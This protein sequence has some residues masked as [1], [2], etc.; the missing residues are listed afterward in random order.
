MMSSPATVAT[1][2]EMP[3]RFA[4]VE[5]R[6]LAGGRIHAARVGD[7]ADAPLLQ[8][9]QHAGDHVDEIARVAG[10]CGSRD[11]CFCRIDMVTSAR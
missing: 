1:L 6:V 4:D 11:R 2:M 7:D 9:G 3:W 5:H 10:T 8:I